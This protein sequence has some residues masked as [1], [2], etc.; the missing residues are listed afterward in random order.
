MTRAPLSVESVWEK[1]MPPERGRDARED[2][3][4][5]RLTIGFIAQATLVVLGLWSLSH[6]LW[7]GREVLFVAFFGALVALFLSSFVT[8]L[9]KLGVPRPLAA[10]V[11][12]L[13][14]LSVLAGLLLITWPT[15]QAQIYMIR[16]NLPAALEDVGR[17]FRVQYEVVTGELGRPQPELAAQLRERLGREAVNL[18]GGALPLLNTVVGAT[19]GLFIV[20]SAGLYLTIE[21][22]VYVEGLTRL[23]PPRGRPR[24]RRALEETASDLRHW[25]LGTAINMV[26]IGVATTVGLV[27]LGIPAALALGLIAGL[28]EFIPIY[29]PILSAV[30]AVAVALLLSPSD[31]IWVAL[32][33]IGIQQFES[34]VLTPLVMRGAVRLPPALTLL[35]G[36]L[37]AVL[38]GFLGLLLAVPIL[39]AAL[40]LVRRLYVENLENGA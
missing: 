33:Y 21:A 9:E 27:L 18:V 23:V 26:F 24:V 35:F 34:N 8:P 19:A 38:F 2:G 10:L 13:A 22:R 37:M 6:I 7:L 14:F 15:L 39:A 29:G 1:E 5:C 17:W 32:L 16:L 36:A 25:I 12:L 4:P 28:L 11:V 30:P 20:I 40:A 3:A 31:A